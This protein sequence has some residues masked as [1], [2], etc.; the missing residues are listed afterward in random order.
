MGLN[1]LEVRQNRFISGE[2]RV[3]EAQNGMKYDK[4]GLNRG[5]YK[6][7]VKMKHAIFSLL[8]AFQAL[9]LLTVSLYSF[10]LD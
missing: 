2:N 5:K 8:Y 10:L 6:H 4:I 3:K 9:T 1:G 7:P